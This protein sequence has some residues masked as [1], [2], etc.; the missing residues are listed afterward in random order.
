MIGPS[1]PMA[2]SQPMV[3]SG[4][5]LSAGFLGLAEQG[6]PVRQRE[7]VE[8][9][10]GARVVA[11]RVEADAAFGFADRLLERA[12]AE[13]DVG[14]QVA[15]VAVVEVVGGVVA[16]HHLEAGEKHPRLAVGGR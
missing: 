3:R 4:Q 7:A 14:Q 12:G 15:R 2:M 13:L 10:A 5:N 6:V 8:G 16:G 11:V 1:G 9:D